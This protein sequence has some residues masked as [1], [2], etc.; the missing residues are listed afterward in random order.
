[1]CE[2]IYSETQ[3]QAFLLMFEKYCLINEFEV[4]VMRFQF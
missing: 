4:T 2:S 1:M 3:E